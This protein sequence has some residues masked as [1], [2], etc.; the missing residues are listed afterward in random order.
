MTADEVDQSTRSSEKIPQLTLAL[1]V[2]A[3]LL[4]ITVSTAFVGAAG[5]TVLHF[6]RPAAESS[7]PLVAIGLWLVSSGSLL[8]IQPWKRRPLAQWPALWLAGRFG[9]FL[10]TVVLAAALLY[11]APHSERLST[12][13]V[14]LAGYA[15][16]FTAELVVAARVFSRLGA[17]PSA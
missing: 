14:F 1:P 3:I 2:R 5:W 12:G 10:G 17:G 16:V 6:V 11:S 8:V 15:L 4:S 7:A 9:S 13:L